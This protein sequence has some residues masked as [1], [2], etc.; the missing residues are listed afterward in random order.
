MSA[1]D[2][3]NSEAERQRRQAD[4]DAAKLLSDAAALRAKLERQGKVT[5]HQPKHKK[6]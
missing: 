4:A 6:K 1:A 2:E 5:K 3:S